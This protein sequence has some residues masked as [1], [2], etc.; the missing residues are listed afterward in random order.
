MQSLYNLLSGSIQVVAS[1][2]N[3][4]MLGE[5]RFIE[6]FYGICDLPDKK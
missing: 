2:N 4:R 6:G 3:K 5:H 1:D